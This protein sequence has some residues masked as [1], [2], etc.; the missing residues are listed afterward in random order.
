MTTNEAD[1]RTR[2]LETAIEVFAAEGFAGA[3]I[4]DIA[5]R[6]GVNKAMVYYHVGDKQALYSAVFQMVAGNGATA[7]EQAIQGAGDSCEAK[8]RAAIAGL[9][10]L[11]QTHPQFP[12]LVLREV[13]SRGAGITPEMVAIISRIYSLLGSILRS[14]AER[15]EFKPV[16]PT[17]IAMHI[18]GSLV[19]LNAAAPV[20][21]KLRERIDPSTVGTE[22]PESMLEAITNIVF[23]GLSK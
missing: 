23:H 2:I 10:G 5:K 11:A 15:G 12:Q 17:L 9:V 6:A 19:F 13:A 14:G 16:D 3:R 22:T 4:D 1:A 18:V 21:E 8:L 7:V 20:R